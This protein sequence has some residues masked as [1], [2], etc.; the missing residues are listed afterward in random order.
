MKKLILTLIVTLGV[1]MGASYA[2]DYAGDI[3]SAP[4][5]KSS[6]MTSFDMAQLRAH[7]IEKICGIQDRSTLSE[8]I[9]AC[10]EYYEAIGKEEVSALSK[11]SRKLNDKMSKSIKKALNSQQKDAFEAWQVTRIL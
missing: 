10:Q 8:I 3:S 11:E 4:S 1:G 9:G 2:Q 7:E 6:V 5:K